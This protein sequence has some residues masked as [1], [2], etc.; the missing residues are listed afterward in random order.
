MQHPKGGRWRYIFT[1]AIARNPHLEPKT[2]K[3]PEP[4]IRNPQTPKPQNPFN[5][6]TNTKQLNRMLLNP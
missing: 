6:E 3:H 1:W 4:R 2:P 5:P